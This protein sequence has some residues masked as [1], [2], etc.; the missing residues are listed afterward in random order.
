[1]LVDYPPFED[2]YL[3]HA[4]LFLETIDFSRCVVHPS[5]QLCNQCQHRQKMPLYKRTYDCKQCG[6]ELDRDLNASINL[7][8]ATEYTM[9]V[10]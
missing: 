8:N 5:S 3:P 9:L 7:V 10:Y 4:M 1:M 6:M 2:G